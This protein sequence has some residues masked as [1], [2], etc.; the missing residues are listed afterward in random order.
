MKSSNKEFKIKGLKKYHM[1]IFLA[2]VI[3][4]SFLSKPSKLVYVSE[5]SEE[6]QNMCKSGE[7][8]SNKLIYEN[9]RCTDLPRLGS[10]GLM[11][12]VES[13]T[14]CKTDFLF[15]RCGDKEKITKK[16]QCLGINDY[17]D[18][19]SVSTVNLNKV[20]DVGFWGTYR[21]GITTLLLGIIFLPAFVII[22][23][24]ATD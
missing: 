8:A 19:G 17:K 22:F 21:T 9:Y 3:L 24:S 14:T 5:R 11:G 13:N 7:I 2:C 16:E 20:T 15:N 4:I 23:F 6:L 12:I 10:Y 1:L 18:C